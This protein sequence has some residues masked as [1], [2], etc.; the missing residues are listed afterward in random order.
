[1][2]APWQPIG[3]REGEFASVHAL[4]LQAWGTRFRVLAER[5]LLVRDRVG[6]ATIAGGCW[7][8]FGM[9]DDLAMAATLIVL[10]EQEWLGECIE[11]ARAASSWGLISA[12]DP[13]SHAG[14]RAVLH[15]ADAALVSAERERNALAMR[16]RDYESDDDGST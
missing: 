14:L 16:R 13:R 2:L 9:E 6:R 8:M 10:A 7:R 1:V 5:D 12:S 11:R 15:I 4:P 3:V